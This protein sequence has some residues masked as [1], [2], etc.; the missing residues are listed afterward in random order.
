MAASIYL[1]TLKNPTSSR[2]ATAW[3]HVHAAGSRPKQV[4]KIRNFRAL[5]RSPLSIRLCFSF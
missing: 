5:G 1:K 4:G 3:L 2:L